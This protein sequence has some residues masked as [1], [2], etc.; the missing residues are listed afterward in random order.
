MA[1]LSVDRRIQTSKSP[2]WVVFPFIGLRSASRHAQSAICESVHLDPGSKGL[3][4]KRFYEANSVFLKIT[5]EPYLL[6]SLHLKGLF[7][8]NGDETM[9]DRIDTDSLFANHND[10]R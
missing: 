2:Q 7:K 5:F 1:T 10:C 4:F 3:K 6:V 9:R 8:K